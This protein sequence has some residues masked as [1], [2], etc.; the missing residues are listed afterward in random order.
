[1]CIKVNEE[2]RQ[3][4]PVLLG[5]FTQSWRCDG[6][7]FDNAKY[8]GRALSAL[9]HHTEWE[10]GFEMVVLHGSIP[11][12]MGIN[13]SSAISMSSR[14]YMTNAHQLNKRSIFFQAVFEV[15]ASCICAFCFVS[16]LSGQRQT[17][18]FVPVLSRRTVMMFVSHRQTVN[19]EL[20]GKFLVRAVASCTRHEEARNVL[21]AC[22]GERD[23]G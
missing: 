3:A 12:L 1:M 10:V 21:N 9:L 14:P 11:G 15:K 17:S 18:L 13:A 20:C 2:H 7:K 8:A 22:C 19:F 23:A 16:F 5:S 6:K 4:S